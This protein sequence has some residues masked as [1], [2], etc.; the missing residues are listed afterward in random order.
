MVVYHFPKCS[1]GYIVGYHSNS[2]V[3]T[4]TIM[5]LYEYRLFPTFFMNW[6]NVYRLHTYINTS[7]DV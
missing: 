4:F 2:A 7:H 3:S 5:F 1:Y 6:Y